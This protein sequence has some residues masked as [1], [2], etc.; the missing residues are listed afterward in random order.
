MVL[1]EIDQC[2]V[3]KPSLEYGFVGFKITPP[4]ANFKENY[5]TMSR[6][7]SSRK[8]SIGRSCFP[9]RNQHLTG[10]DLDIWTAIFYR[11]CIRT[12]LLSCFST[13]LFAT[14]TQIQLDWREIGKL[15]NHLKLESGDTPRDERR[16]SF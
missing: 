13:N 10:L 1:D 16:F 11:L 5:Q 12:L 2:V 9:R 8:P 3:V 4:F 15:S 7:F 14:H 6:G